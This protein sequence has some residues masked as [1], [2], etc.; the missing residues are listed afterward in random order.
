M[1]ELQGALGS[2]RSAKPRK[3]MSCAPGPA[4]PRH[5]RIR[6]NS[7]LKEQTHFDGCSVAEW[8]NMLYALQSERME[9]ALRA[10][11]RTPWIS[12]AGVPQREKP[13]VRSRKSQPRDGL[14]GKTASSE[15]SDDRSTV[16]QGLCSHIENAS[17]VQDPQVCAPRALLASRK[18]ANQ[19]LSAGATHAGRHLRVRGR[20]SPLGG[21]RSAARAPS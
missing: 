3:C 18:P 10:L 1:R 4:P 11:L 15:P 19:L 9:L 20:C 5:T 14:S 7:Q 8:K 12:F 6:W 21:L 2:V 17:L 13:Q 16:V